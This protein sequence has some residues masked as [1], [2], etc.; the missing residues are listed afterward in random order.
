MLDNPP[1]VF[2]S[3]LIIS[4]FELNADVTN[5]GCWYDFGANVQSLATSQKWLTSVYLSAPT[6]NLT[7]E[8]RHAAD[9]E[10]R[11]SAITYGCSSQNQEDAQ[12]FG[13]PK[14]NSYKTIIILLCVGCVTVCCEIGVGVWA[15][16]KSQAFYLY[17]KYY[18]SYQCITDIDAEEISSSFSCRELYVATEPAQPTN[19]LQL[20]VDL[21]VEAPVE[22]PLDSPIKARE[23]QAIQEG[24]EAIRE[25][26]AGSFARSPCAEALVHI[27]YTEAQD[28]LDPENSCSLQ[29][30]ESSLSGHYGTNTYE[31]YEEG[32]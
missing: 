23:N 14:S 4:L 28:T 1:S 32:I 7:V 8:I 30:A 31:G 22:I 19:A 9:P 10:V 29:H 2:V 18:R 3:H 12:C 13:L 17:K 5:S 21:P 15:A 25:N 11:V 20:T 27:S 6:K 26:D 24:R 16:N